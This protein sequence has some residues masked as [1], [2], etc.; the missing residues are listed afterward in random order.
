[1]TGQPSIYLLCGEDEFAIEEVVSK[2]VIQVG[3]DPTLAEMN[4]SHLDGRLHTHD[5]L[6]KAVHAMPFLVAQRLVFYAHPTAKIK[7]ASHQKKLIDLLDRL[8]PTTL[9][10]LTE[11]E[12]FTS[13]Y[14]RKKAKVHWLE[15][16]A[17]NAGER[18]VFRVFPL[19]VGP[20][21]VQWIQ[22]RAEKGGGKF[23]PAAADALAV[24]VGPQPRMLDQEVNKLLAY[25]NY[26]RPVE[27]DDV[28]H[29]TP[30]TAPVPD[31]G[32]VNALRS[33]D[34]RKALNILH[35]ELEEKEPLQVFGSIT[36]QFRQVLLVRE[37][38]DHGGGKDEIAR[39][40]SMHPF[41]AEKA[42]EHAR[43]Y[44]IAQLEKIYRRL[45]ELDTGIKTGRME[46]ELALDLLVLELT[47]AS[48]RN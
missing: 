3:G 35:R 36:S 9:L 26:A 41:A 12:A 22:R 46:N 16:W 48:Q 37:I 2:L 32:L 42:M 4:T 21:L 18:V 44:T 14:E 15:R 6:V 23:T 17:V 43:A 10:I 7:H 25:V 34:T 45:L 13:D 8:P 27:P 24:M 39:V 40:L 5:D 28:Q 19:P 31:F 30:L 11:D 38:M 33:Q 47:N 20:A 29:I 1:V